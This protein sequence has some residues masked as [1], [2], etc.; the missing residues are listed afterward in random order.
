MLLFQNIYDAYGT[1]NELSKLSLMI[2]LSTL[3]VCRNLA[4]VYGYTIQKAAGF[5]MEK[6]PRSIF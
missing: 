5:L 1:L 2:L 4:V 3:H 6:R